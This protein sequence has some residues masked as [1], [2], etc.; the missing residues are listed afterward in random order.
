VSENVIR[1]IIGSLVDGVS[2]ET[3]E[4]IRG[5]RGSNDMYTDPDNNK[6]LSPKWIVPSDMGVVFSARK[7]TRRLF[8]S[9]K[10]VLTISN[11][12]HHLCVFVGF[13]FVRRSFSVNVQNPHY[14]IVFESR[15]I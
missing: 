1:V 14:M 11:D 8:V 6:L 4:P 5:R 12:L 9:P 15:S 10:C 13:S 7:Y 3:R 2:S